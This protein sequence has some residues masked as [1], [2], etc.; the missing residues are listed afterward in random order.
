MSVFETTAVVAVGEFA[1]AVGDKR[2]SE[3]RKSVV[4]ALKFVPTCSLNDK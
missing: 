2:R 1:G 3:E 4:P